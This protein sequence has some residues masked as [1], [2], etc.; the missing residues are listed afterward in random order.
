MREPVR[1]RRPARD[2]SDVK[3]GAPRAEVITPVTAVQA[4][5]RRTGNAATAALLSRWVDLVEDKPVENSQPPKGHWPLGGFWVRFDEDRWARDNAYR[6]KMMRH[7]SDPPAVAEPTIAFQGDL[8]KT[9]DLDDQLGCSNCVAADY[10]G[11]KLSAFQAQFKQPRVG[12]NGLEGDKFFKQVGIE[13]TLEVFD[14]APALHTSLFAEEFDTEWSGAL[15]WGGH[16][17]RVR[18]T[19]GAFEAWDPQGNLGADALVPSDVQLFLFT[20]S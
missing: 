1:T 2:A 18:V 8:T 7:R 6:E 11:M 3:R 17:I 14:N 19:S 12:R 9:N 20:F 5:Q 4:L 15:A 16:I 13:T 10:F